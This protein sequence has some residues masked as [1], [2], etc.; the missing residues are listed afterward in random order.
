MDL[1]PAG[2]TPTFETDGGE[3][4][5]FADYLASVGVVDSQDVPLGLDRRIQRIGARADDVAA[6]EIASLLLGPTGVEL[7]VQTLG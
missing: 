1:V 3:Q 5:A 7:E 2:V 6:P 4:K